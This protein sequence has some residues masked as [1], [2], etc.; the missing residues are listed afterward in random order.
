[1]GSLIDTYDI[2]IK[3][4]NFSNLPSSD[5]GNKIDI[6]FC[7]FNKYIPFI[8]N[9]T[10]SIKLIVAAHPYSDFPGKPKNCFNINKK[11]FELSQMLYHDIPHENYDI[12]SVSNL[13]IPYIY[14]NE[15]NSQVLDFMSFTR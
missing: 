1:M 2:V 15:W 14:L 3:I 11:F 5:Y 6:L 4:N 8:S 9:K 10:D 7:S 13:V 12:N